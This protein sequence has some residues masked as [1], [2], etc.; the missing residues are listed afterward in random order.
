[1]GTPVVSFDHGGISEVVTHERTG[2][3]APEGD[4]PALAANL[5][6][7]L[8][9]DATWAEFSNNGRNEV[10]GRFDIVQ[11]TA[12]LEEIYAQVLA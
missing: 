3:L 7:L 6:R 8:R 2:L 11:Q 10:H 9:D 1:M 4:S 5:L 12:K